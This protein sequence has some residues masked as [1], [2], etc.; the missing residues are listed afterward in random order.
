MPGRVDL[1][2]LLILSWPG[3]RETLRENVPAKLCRLRG[4]LGICDGAGDGAGFR[5]LLYGGGSRMELGGVGDPLRPGLRESLLVKRLTDLGG[6]GDAERS[7]RGVENGRV[8]AGREVRGGGAEDLRNGKGL[9]W[10]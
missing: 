3:S 2:G 10:E 7:R 8:D 9:A 1:V 5:S 4:V 6:A